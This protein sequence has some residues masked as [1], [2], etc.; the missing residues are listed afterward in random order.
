MVKC[1]FCGKEQDKV[2][3]MIK[4][5]NDSDVAI[6]SECV[7]LCNQIIFED[8]VTKTVKRVLAKGYNISIG[9]K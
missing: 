6:C 1:S 5:N 3:K 7:D 2:E 4:A 9:E 8:K